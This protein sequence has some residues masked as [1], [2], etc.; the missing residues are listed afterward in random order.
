MVVF[1]EKLYDLQQKTGHKK[2]L[3]STIN[4]LYDQKRELDRNMFQLKCKM[5]KEQADV[6]KLSKPSLST[7]FTA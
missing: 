5:N 7:F 3:Q 2:H 6:D 1:D 4:N